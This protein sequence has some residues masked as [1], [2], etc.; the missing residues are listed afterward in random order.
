MGV[1]I[2]S[3][4]L[5]AVAHN[6]LFAQILV[7]AFIII[8]AGSVTLVNSVFSGFDAPVWRG[9]MGWLISIVLNTLGYDIVVTSEHLLVLAVI[10][11]LMLFALRNRASV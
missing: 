11:P 5:S 2:V 4:T 7:V 10:I 3:E 1:P 8:D 6:P 9:V